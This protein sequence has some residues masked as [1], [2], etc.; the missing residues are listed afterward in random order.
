MTYSTTTCTYGLPLE[1]DKTG[2]ITTLVPMNGDNR[3]YDFG[4]STCVTVQDDI[5]ITI[6]SSTAT[7]T[8]QYING[9]SYGETII[10]LFLMVLVFNSFFGGILNRLLG[11]KQKLGY[12]IKL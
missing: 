3:N 4:T 1:T 11:T 5:L 9:F 12:R 10:S 8:A 2:M 7:N 6:A